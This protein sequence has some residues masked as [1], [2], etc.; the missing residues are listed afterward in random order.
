M[1]KEITS[2]TV[3]GYGLAAGASIVGIAASKDFGAAPDGFKPSDLLSDCLSVVVLGALFP[4]ESLDNVALYTETRN[5]MLTKMTETAKEVAKRIKS[6]GYSAKEI[7]ASGGKTIDSNHFG[8]ISLKHAAELAGL[9]I[10]G[11]NYLLI[12]PSYGNLLWLSAVLT[13]AELVPDQKLQYNICEDCN[14]CVES[15][16]SGALADY[17]AKFG[18]KECAKFFKIVDKKF[19]IQCFKCRTVC[20]YRFGI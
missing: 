17:P 8:H 6:C 14:I 5:A 2:E 1:K 13:D 20:P 7:S 18:K 11:R 16:P 9:G 12:N 3:K 10:I 15:C 4:K 19:Q